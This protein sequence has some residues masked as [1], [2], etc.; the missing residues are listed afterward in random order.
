MRRGREG[1]EVRGR[2]G[3]LNA[4]K[5]L[6]FCFSCSQAGFALQTSQRDCIAGEERHLQLLRN[7]NKKEE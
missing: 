5:A 6:D 3:S 2:E 7:N 4:Q 1:R